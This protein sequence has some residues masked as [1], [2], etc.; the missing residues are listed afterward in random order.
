MATQQQTKDQ[1]TRDQLE[2][3]TTVLNSKPRQPKLDRY[4]QHTLIYFLLQ[5]SCLNHL[6]LIINCFTTNIEKKESKERIYNGVIVRER[7]FK[8]ENH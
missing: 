1:D 4:P 3:D 7:S 2:T 6:L 5:W 8:H